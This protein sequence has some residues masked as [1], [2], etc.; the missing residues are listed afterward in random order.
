VRA[1]T[2]RATSDRCR[3]LIGWNVPSAIRR[4]SA[5]RRY[6]FS[7]HSRGK[8]IFAALQSCQAGES[9]TVVLRIDFEGMKIN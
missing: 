4:Y 1:A 9:M 6:E 8:R 5:F 3:P 2:P 7:L